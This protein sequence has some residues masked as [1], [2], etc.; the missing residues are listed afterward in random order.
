MIMRALLSISILILSHIALLGQDNDTTTL[1]GGILK[2]AVVSAQSIIK[3]T[4]TR[5]TLTPLQIKVKPA[6][7]GEMDP[8]KVVLTMPGIQN[9]VEGDV[10]ISVR[11][12]DVDQ[13]LVSLDGVAIYNPSHMKGFV[14]AFNSD[15]VSQ[16]DIFK[17][18]FPAKYGS[19]LSGVVDVKTKIGDMQKFGGS[20]NLGMMSSKIFLEGPIFKGRTS[21]TFSA[22]KSYFGLIV[23]NIYKKIVKG[24]DDFFEQLKHTG[25]YDVNAGI[26]QLI[27]DNHKID[28]RFYR[29]DDKIST[30]NYTDHTYSLEVED[31]TII[32][33]SGTS[34]GENWGNMAGLI[35][36]DYT[37]S[38][39][40]DLSTYASYS[41]FRHAYSNR[42][43]KQTDSLCPSFKDGLIRTI[44]EENLLKRQ[45]YIEEFAVGSDARLHLPKGHTLS[46]GIRGSKQILLP[47]ILASNTVTHI[48]PDK[49]DSIL[50]KNNDFGSDYGINTYSIYA[51]DDFTIGK[52]LNISAGIRFTIYDLMEK[53]HYIPEPRIRCSWVIT[54]NFSL[55]GSYSRM[56]QPIHLLSSSNIISPSDLWV[57]STAELPPMLSDNFAFGGWY[58]KRMDD[59][60]LMF[61]LEGYYKTME[62]TLDYYQSYSLLSRIDW[63]DAVEVGH[64]KSYGMEVFTNIRYKTFD[65]TIAYTLSKTL[66]QYETINFGEWFPSTQDCRHNLSVQ[67]SYIPFENF[68]VS[69]AFYYKTGRRYTLSDIVLR[70]PYHRFYWYTDTSAE[71]NH[72]WILSNAYSYL[73]KNGYKMEDYHRMDLSVNYRFEHKKSYSDINL[74]VYNAYN[75]MNPYKLSFET[76]TDGKVTVKKLCVFPIMPSIN[77]IFTF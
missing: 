33:N 76:G 5:T 57:P 12:G 75:R 3:E 2:E 74:S 25:Y 56:S 49:E 60:Y 51:E 39:K 4:S 11:G 43:T 70:T 34:S 72:Y 44:Q 35:R 42:E 66:E 69:A 53:Y 63:E 27:G 37:K 23:G 30:I 7:F 54:P 9:N 13:T 40:I 67:V 26:T 18:A 41:I 36:W 24:N 10:G 1:K 46:F 32:R 48:V 17:S 77:Y 55:K 45:S 61:S 68:T 19:R 47:K 31:I 52:K 21:F 59:L 64:A 71:M 29:G 8:L 73:E 14:S 15:V 58:E 50:V 22:R 20:L 6:L 65:A 38:N 28:V 16:I 62:N